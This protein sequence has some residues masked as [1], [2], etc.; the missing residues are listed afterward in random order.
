MAKNRTSW[1]K[2]KKPHESRTLHAGEEGIPYL[3][4]YL[5]FPLEKPTPDRDSGPEMLK[6]I[7][8]N[9][10]IRC[11]NPKYFNDPWD[12]KPCV[13]P[14]L[15][16]DPA[17]RRMMAESLIATQKGGPKGDVFDLR[18]LHDPA[19]LS[20][21]IA[22]FNSFIS[23]YITTRWGIVCLSAVPCSTL[24]WSHYADNHKGICLEFGARDKIFGAALKVIYRSEYPKMLLGGNFGQMMLTVKAKD[25]EKEEE[26]RLA[27][28]LSEEV[29]EVKE[30]PLVMKD[31]FLEIGDLLHAVI[32][33]CEIGAE[34]ERIIKELRK[35]QGHHVLLKRAVRVFH[36][37]NLTLEDVV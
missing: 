10:R 8:V 5:R 21:N 28:P 16:G 3:Y 1:Q 30:S 31:G 24:M 11:S 18:L 36:R 9:R 13:H 22:G 37:Y 35:E 7:L 6:N 20:K 2:A 17:A 26:Y 33:G 27:C 15:L 32:M 25:W 14:D 29:T 19:F 12:C 4:R 23:E 34:E